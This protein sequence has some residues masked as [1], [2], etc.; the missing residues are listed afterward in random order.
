MADIHTILP[1]ESIVDSTNAPLFDGQYHLAFVTADIE[2]AQECLAAQFGIR[3][4]R[5]RHN[6]Q[7]IWSAHAFAGDMMI[8][9]VQPGP[10]APPVFHQDRPGG[11]A[12]RLHHI[13][14]R[15]RDAQRFSEIEAIVEREG[16][17]TPLRS[18]SM[19]GH[20]RVIFIDARA[21]LGFFQEYVLLTGPALRLYDDV[22]FN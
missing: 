15:V 16:W 18:S 20:L 11:G 22:P 17:E 6:P 14:Y 12:V 13:G 1:R 2:A 19:D 3:E 7:A 10:D 8:E 5:V 21:T 9:I 4:Y